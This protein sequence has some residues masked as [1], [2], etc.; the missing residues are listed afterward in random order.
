MSGRLLLPSTLLLVGVESASTRLVGFC[1][2]LL[3]STRL[4]PSTGIC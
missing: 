1:G 2:V 3:P 4:L